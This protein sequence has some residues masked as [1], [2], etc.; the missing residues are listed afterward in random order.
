M[1]S[2]HRSEMIVLENW[3][4]NG[5]FTT[6]DCSA[7]KQILSKYLINWCNGIMKENLTKMISQIAVACHK[8]FLSHSY[9]DGASMTPLFTERQPHE[10]LLKRVLSRREPSLV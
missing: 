3:P 5:T 2:V 7:Q 1:C 4:R 6:Q 9:F 10:C 8:V